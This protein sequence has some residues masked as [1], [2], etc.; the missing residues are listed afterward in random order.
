M[1]PHESVIPVDAKREVGVEPELPALLTS[2]P[3]IV[4]Q[5]VLGVEQNSRMK[6]LT[7]SRPQ[8]GGE[9][10][11]APHVWASVRGADV[12]EVVVHPGTES[13]HGL[14]HNVDGI[15]YTQWHR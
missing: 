3:I 13:E 1:P 4:T 7:S 9:E 2:F 6:I 10:K 8:W 14:A 12:L 15:W 11:C 5:H